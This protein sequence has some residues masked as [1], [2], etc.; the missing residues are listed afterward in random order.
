MRL[1]DHTAFIFDLDGTLI[2]SAAQIMHCLRVAFMQAGRAADESLFVPRRVGPPIRQIL[3]DIDPALPGTAVAEEIVSHFRALY[4][5][6]AN[7]PSRLY[8]HVQTFLTRLQTLQKPLFVATFKPKIPV[9]RLLEQLGLT[10]TFQ[11]V[12]TIDKYAAPMTKTQ[13]VQD[14]IQKHHL[15]AQTTLLLGD[16]MSDLNA[17]HAAGAR[18]AAC[19]W[20]YAQDKEALSRAADYVFTSPEELLQ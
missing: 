13:M 8:P 6:T 5:H 3:A 18:S 19:L 17:A 12:Y 20:G 16:M 4:D 1:L 11:E 2:D 7:D 9:G 15:P 10:N 14:L